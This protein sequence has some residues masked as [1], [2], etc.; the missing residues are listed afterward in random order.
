MGCHLETRQSLIL[1]NIFTLEEEIKI[2]LVK[3]TDT[4]K[5]ETIAKYFINHD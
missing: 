4:E 2:A 3:M 1:L 5:L